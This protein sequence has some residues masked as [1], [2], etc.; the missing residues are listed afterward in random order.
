MRRSFLVPVSLLGDGIFSPDTVKKRKKSCPQLFGGYDVSM[1]CRPISLHE[2]NALIPLIQERMEELNEYL[3]MLETD[4]IPEAAPISEGASQ[5][6]IVLSSADLENA[7]FRTAIE[8]QIRA[9]AIE[10]QKF[11]AYVREIYPGVVDFYSMR[12]GQAVRL[13][14]HFGEDEVSH[15]QPYDESGFHE[16]YRISDQDVFGRKVLQ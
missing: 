4:T 15:W 6:E 5:E 3:V 13:T 8:D 14:W 11:G 1:L 2:A 16:A 12:A 10:L 7:A 9:K